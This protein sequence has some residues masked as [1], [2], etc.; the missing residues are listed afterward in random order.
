MKTG[1][2]EPRKSAGYFAKRLKESGVSVSESEKKE[3]IQEPQQQQ[4]G[5]IFEESTKSIAAMAGDMSETAKIAS[6]MREGIQRV[7]KIANIL[8]SDNP[9]CDNQGCSYDGVEFSADQNPDADQQTE[10]NQIR[11]SAQEAEK[12]ANMISEYAK[13]N[14]SDMKS[15]TD[16]IRR[17]LQEFR[18]KL[19]QKES[20]LTD[21]RSAINHARTQT[22]ELTYDTEQTVQNSD[23][24]QQFSEFDVATS[25]SDS[26]N[27]LQEFDKFAT[28][29][30]QIKEGEKKLLELRWKMKKIEME[31]QQKAAQKEELDNITDDIQRLESKR[32]Q[33]KA[34]IRDLENQNKEPRQELKDLQQKIEQAKKDYEEKF[35]AKKELDDVRSI[36][37]YLK[38]DKEA[39]KS[40]LEE[41]RAKIKQVEK[42]YEEK[43]AAKD[44]LED[45]RFEVSTLKAEKDTLGAELEQLNLRIKKAE[46]EYEEKKAEK[47]KLGELKAVITH[48]KIEKEAVESELAELKAR[49]KKAEIE[50]QQKKAAVEE[51]QEVREIIAY[52]KPERDSLKAELEQLRE[53]IQKTQD[54]YDQINAKKRDL[55]LEYEELKFKLRKTESEYEEK[56][57]F[58]RFTR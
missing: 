4:A 32:D 5:Q 27:E 16:L 9:L 12:I 7:N 24:L 58:S 44:Q 45:V 47:E 31:Y 6:S 55:Q 15:D 29:Q 18:D 54:T 40:D 57:D 49:I 11:L 17:E 8:N 2:S 42:E 35:A 20:E 10:T 37:D 53:K 3:D 41:L 1:D 48:L 26:I 50:Y 38:L 36:L 23:G 33:L 14:I 28:I 39:L 52:L 25:S 22:G 19:K 30:R 21:F 34:E 46:S 51:L 43:K 13:K 56:K